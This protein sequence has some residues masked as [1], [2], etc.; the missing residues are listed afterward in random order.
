MS[1]AFL[2]NDQANLDLPWNQNVSQV[3][4]WNVSPS[5]SVDVPKKTN[6]K[7]NM[8][9]YTFIM[10]RRFTVKKQ[11]QKNNNPRLIISLCAQ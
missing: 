5:E 6:A 4:Q 10:H 3:L 9:V 2:L 1:S 8:L 11:Q 7:N